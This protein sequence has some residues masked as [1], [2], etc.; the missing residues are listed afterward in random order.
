MNIP[1]ILS[2]IR[3]CLVPVFILVYFGDSPNSNIG[4][5]IVYAVASITDVLD[6]R[7][8]RKYNITTNLGRILDPLGDKLMTMAVIV[9][10]TIDRVIPVWAVIV[11]LIKECM[12]GLGGMFLYNKFEEMPPSNFF[13]KCSTIVFFAVC[14]I[15]ML[16]RSISHTGALV[17]ISFA[18][19]VM[20][21]A[22]ASY[23]VRFVRMMKSSEHSKS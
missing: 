4:A 19:A 22:F 13:G 14:V 1:N 7:I 15:L 3:I 12:M 8:A 10:I 17:M 6:G 18:L 23:A 9:C 16:F 11:F 21:L 2:V 20:L 5:A